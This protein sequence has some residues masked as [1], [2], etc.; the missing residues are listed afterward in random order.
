MI[1]EM[2]AGI[3]PLAT[4]MVLLGIL[5]AAV[6]FGAMWSLGRLSDLSTDLLLAVRRKRLPKTDA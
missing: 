5:P 6:L 4:W 2:I 3:G 1:N